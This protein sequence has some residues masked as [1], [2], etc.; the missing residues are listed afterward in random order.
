MIRAVIFDWA[1]TTVDFGSLAPVRTLE[2][3]FAEAGIT[4]TETEARRD[5]GIAKHDHIS[6]LLQNTRIASA[7]QEQY[8]HLAD[9]KDRNALYQRFIPLQLACLKE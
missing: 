7:W 5:M 2:R 6:A 4:I 9:D 3:V 8:G 1:G